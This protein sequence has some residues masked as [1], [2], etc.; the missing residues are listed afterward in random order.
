MKT[1]FCSPH[2]AKIAE[3]PYTVQKRC[4]QDQSSY[5][6][7][8]TCE[9][10]QRDTGRGGKPEQKVLRPAATVPPQVTSA[11]MTTPS[12]ECPK[13]VR[14]SIDGGDGPWQRSCDEVHQFRE[15]ACEGGWFPASR[16]S[17]TFKGPD[18]CGY[19][20]KT[21]VRNRA[22]GF[23]GVEREEVFACPD[24]Q[25]FASIE[26]GEKLLENFGVVAAERAR[27]CTRIHQLCSAS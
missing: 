3:E 26:R 5:Y 13:F 14:G 21:N 25:V 27:H 20:S 1:F 22:L 23:A 2:R 17:R 15:R 16:V 12:T 24:A 10:S 6:W 19:L 9:G 18:S 7:S 8:R 4:K 11:V